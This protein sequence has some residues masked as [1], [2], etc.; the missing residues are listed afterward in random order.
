MSAK[1]Q[2]TKPRKNTSGSA[3]GKTTQAKPAPLNPRQLRFIDEYLVDLNGTHAAIRAGYSRNGADVQAVRLLGDARIA[4]AIEEGRRKLA[5]RTQISAERVL[6][7]VSRLAFLD[8]RRAFDEDGNLKPMAE[9]DDDTAAAIAG[10]EVFEEYQGRGQDR[11]YLGRTKKIKLSDKKGA[12]ELL[13]RHL[14]LLNDKLKL[15][16]DPEN[17][18]TLLL[19]QVEGTALKPRTTTNPPSQE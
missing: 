8:I 5:E 1:K 4:A 15:G 6:Q 13:M 10:L 11:E 9:L 3:R 18:L 7:E 19:Q 14:G 16:S 12:L 2:T 17:P